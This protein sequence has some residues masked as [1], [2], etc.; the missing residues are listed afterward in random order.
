MSLGQAL[1]HLSPALLPLVC[2]SVGVKRP[3]ALAMYYARTR[4]MWV[5]Q[6]LK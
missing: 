4:I 2:P 6:Q 3:H 1:R 5:S